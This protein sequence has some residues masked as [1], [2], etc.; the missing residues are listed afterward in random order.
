MGGLLNE[1]IPDAHVAQTEGSQIGDH[2]LSTSCGVIERPDYHCGNHLVYMLTGWER[3]TQVFHLF[4]FF[5]YLR[6]AERHI[7]TVK[8]ASS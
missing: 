5:F 3:K 8:T 7:E 1:L 6:Y 4:K 2:R